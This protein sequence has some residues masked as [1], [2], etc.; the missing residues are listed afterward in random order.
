MNNNDPI[1]ILMHEHR[2]ISALQDKI[3]PLR[4]MWETDA[5][6]Y[7]K[8]VRSLLGFFREYSDQYH[9]HK[10]EAVLFRE[11]R[12]HPDFRLD[13]ILYE[14][15]NHH[16]MFRET[17]AEIEASIANGEWPLS[18]DLLEV[19]MN[20]LLDHIAVEDD[21]LFVTA[22]SLF[23]AGD[24]ERMYFL[25]EDVDRELGK[26]RKEKLAESVGKI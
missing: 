18:Q 9:H 23:S 16:Q 7:D 12:A 2:V 5:A 4:G 25:F 17:V 22:A 3:I 15:E 1:Q 6:G 11:L 13:D 8:L 19:Y 20:D 24:L 14:L 26:E 21:E 10:E